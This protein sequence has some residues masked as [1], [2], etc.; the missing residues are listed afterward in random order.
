MTSLSLPVHSATLRSHPASSAKL[1]NCFIEQL[2]PDAKTPA[3]LLRAPGITGDTTIG[4]GPIYGMHSGLDLMFV[5]SGESLYKVTDSLSSTLL[6]SVGGASLTSIDMANN[7]DSV[8]VVNTPH[9]YYWDGTTFG[10]I[11]DADFTSRGATDV[12]FCDNWI[13]FIEPNSGRLFGAD[14]GTVTDFDALNFVTAEGS[15]DNLVGMKVDHRQVIL[16]GTDSVEIFENTGAA[17]FPFERAIN[18]FIEMGCLN[19]RTIAKQDNSVFWLASDFT[20][21]KLDGITPIRASTHSIE[22]ELKSVTLTDGKAFTY[23]QEGHLFY[24]LTF[25]ETTMVLDITTGEWAHRKSYGYDY[26]QAKNHV[27]A[28]NNQYVGSSIDNKIGYLN[29][30]DYDEWGGVQVMEWTYQPIYAEGQLAFHDRLEIIMETGVGLST[31]Q[32]SD[33]TV[34]LSYSN[35]GGIT[36]IYLPARSA[37][38][39][40]QYRWRVVWHRLGSSRMRT[41]RASISDPVRVTVT[42]TLVQ[43]RGGRL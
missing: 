12:E 2:P 1:V 35:D 21:R 32:G 8:V 22:Q 38:A 20:I 29:T 27:Q 7:T 36:W 16:F 24:V 40:G 25:P 5:V 18:G 30:T 14:L 39:M 34:I 4:N 3:A 23:T 41:Y 31:G 9:A 11:T 28:F 6:G 10:Q 17:G 37:G 26:W 33:P 15:P 43:V 19:G 13:L 42:D